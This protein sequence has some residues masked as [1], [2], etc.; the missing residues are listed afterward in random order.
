MLII[1]MNTELLSEWFHV[2]LNLSQ[3]N[4]SRT[5]HLLNNEYVSFYLDI[6]SF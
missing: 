3:K 2:S 6:P 4:T 1:Y 5:Q